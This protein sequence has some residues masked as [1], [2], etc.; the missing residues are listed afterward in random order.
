MDFSD[1]STVISLPVLVK[2]TDNFSDK[3]SV[4]KGAYGEVYKAL[5]NGQEIAVKKIHPL[6][7]LNDEPF[8]NEIKK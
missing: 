4:G 3:K 1:V 5:Y 2:I 8:D 7:G 6:A